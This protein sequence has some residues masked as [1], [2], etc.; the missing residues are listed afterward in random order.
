MIL[1][2]ARSVA[3]FFL[4]TYL[5]FLSFDKF[6]DAEENPLSAKTAIFLGLVAA[7]SALSTPPNP[8]RKDARDVPPYLQYA[9]PYLSNYIFTLF[10][11]FTREPAYAILP[12]ANSMYNVATYATKSVFP[13]ASFIYFVAALFYFDD[14]GPAH[15]VS[16]SIKKFMGFERLRSAKDFEGSFLTG[17]DTA[18]VNPIAAPVLILI[19]S[20]SLLFTSSSLRYSGSFEEIFNPDKDGIENIS[21]FVAE[22]RTK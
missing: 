10:I 15:E 3:V 8:L 16:D 12:L 6:Q 21:R 18:L 5:G 9:F 11:V 7:A 22:L 13:V 2:L 14:S 20:A 1:A 17:A 4:F 19:F